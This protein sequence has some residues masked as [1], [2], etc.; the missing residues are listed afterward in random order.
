LRK[1]L[2]RFVVVFADEESDVQ[3]GISGKRLPIAKPTTA[4]AFFDGIDP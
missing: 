4:T 2:A 3:L 1:G